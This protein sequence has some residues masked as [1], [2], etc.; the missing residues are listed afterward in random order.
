LLKPDNYLAFAL[1]H[2]W[3]SELLYVFRIEPADIAAEREAGMRDWQRMMGLSDGREAILAP[4][5]RPALGGMTGW[6][7]IFGTASHGRG[8]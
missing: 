5:D 1:G 3:I 2:Q 8:S 6:Q 7:S 4:K